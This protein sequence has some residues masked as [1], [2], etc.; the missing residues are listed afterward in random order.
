MNYKYDDNPDN[1]YP[2]YYCL[3]SSKKQYN[4]LGSFVTMK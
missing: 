1:N 3:E 2:G 4:E